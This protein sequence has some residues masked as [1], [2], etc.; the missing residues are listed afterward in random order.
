MDEH[1][2]YYHRFI[3]R[4]QLVAPGPDTPSPLQRVQVN[5]YLLFDDLI[6]IPDAACAHYA[7]GTF[8][9]PYQG[10]GRPYRPGVAIALVVDHHHS[11]WFELGHKSLR[12]DLVVPVTFPFLKVCRSLLLGH[13]LV[14]RHIAGGNGDAYYL[15]RHVIG[16]FP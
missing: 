9:D 15:V 10:V 13:H 2:P 4:F 16:V 7:P 12:G 6:G 1:A 14:G 8:L 11:A 5:G 3:H